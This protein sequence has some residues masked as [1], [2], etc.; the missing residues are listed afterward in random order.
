MKTTVRV[1][2][3]SLG[4]LLVAAAPAL[5]GLWTN[6]NETLVRDAVPKARA[7]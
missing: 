4:T 2:S 5:A 7:K 3:I 6:H 1:L